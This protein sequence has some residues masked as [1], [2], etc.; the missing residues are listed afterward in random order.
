MEAVSRGGPSASMGP[1]YVGAFRTWYSMRRF[2]SRPSGGVV[3]RYG[4]GFAVSLGDQHVGVR[5]VLD[6]RLPHR[7]GALLR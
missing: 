6:Q 1:D 2:F 7:F 4:I 5:A 3:A